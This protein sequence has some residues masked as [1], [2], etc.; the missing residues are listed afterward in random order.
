MLILPLEIHSSMSSQ[1]QVSEFSSKQE[2]N[3]FI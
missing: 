1:L 3:G 2:N